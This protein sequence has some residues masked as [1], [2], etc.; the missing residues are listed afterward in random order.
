MVQKQIC[1]KDLKRYYTMHA[2]PKDIYN[3]LTNQKM[4]EIWSGEDAKMEPE[5]N[6]EF[7]MWNGSISGMNL[8]FEE[9]RKI[10]QK[11][12]FGEQDEDSV[13]TILL[14]PDKKG[15]KVE[16]RQTNIPDEAYENISDGWDEDYFGAMNELFI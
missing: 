13:V 11:W 7:S 12:F 5:P 1:M 3:A 10:V 4:I 9:N 2:E 15:T 8:E 16:L 14:H 6:T